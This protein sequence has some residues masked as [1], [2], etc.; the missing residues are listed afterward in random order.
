MFVIE[1]FVFINVLQIGQLNILII[2]INLKHI[3]T[4][5]KKIQQI[6][7]KNGIRFDKGLIF[8]TLLP[9][10]KLTIR[11]LFVESSSH[12]AFNREFLLILTQFAEGSLPPPFAVAVTFDAASVTSAAGHLALS[13]GH[14]ALR[15]LPAFFAVAHPA[16]V[17]SMGR[18]QHRAD[19]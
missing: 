13:R 16:P 11:P 1:I 14:V 17:V 18:A 2:R 15:S 8:L 5:N 4:S 10:N 12:F 19:T 6:G 3:H 7:S 9:I